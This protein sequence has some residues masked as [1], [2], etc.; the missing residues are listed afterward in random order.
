MNIALRFRQVKIHLHKRLSNEKLLVIAL[1]ETPSIAASL[2]TR[3]HKSS[4]LAEYCSNVVCVFPLFSLGFKSFFSIDFVFM[5]LKWR[6]RPLV[7][8]SLLFWNRRCSHLFLPT[9]SYKIAT[10][11]SF[12]SL[13]IKKMFIIKYFNKTHFVFTFFTQLFTLIK[14]K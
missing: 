1:I 14:T 2:E 5:F 12:P 7:L 3:R 8:C 13:P 9:F 6:I 11:L 4:F 10:R